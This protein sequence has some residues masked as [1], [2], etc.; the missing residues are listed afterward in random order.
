[1][2]SGCAYYPDARRDLLIPI[3]QDVQEEQGYLSRQ[4]IID[5]GKHLNLPAS[6]IY[7][8]AT[9]YNQF[10]FVPQGECHIQVCRGTA[11]LTGHCELGW[12]GLE[13]REAGDRTD[14]ERGGGQPRLCGWSW[15]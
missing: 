12:A 14:G 9:F 15:S 13:E 4:N 1:M 3:L 2:D 10:T 8:V 11:C 5:V 6:K 7:G